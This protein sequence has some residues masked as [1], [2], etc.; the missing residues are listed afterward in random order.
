MPNRNYL[1]SSVFLSLVGDNSL[2]HEL[3]VMAAV[4]LATFKCNM[5]NLLHLKLI[6]EKSQYIMGGKLLSFEV[7]ELAQGL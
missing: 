3:R 5:P 4:D 1:F 6:Y 2:V 7:F